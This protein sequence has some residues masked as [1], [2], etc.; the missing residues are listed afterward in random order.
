MEQWETFERG[1]PRAP[2]FALELP[3][4]Y[5]RHGAEQWEEGRMRNI[6]RSGLLF[7]A[8]RAF[9]VNTRIELTFTLPRVI[10][11][12]PPGAVR[13]QSQV[14]RSFPLGAEKGQHA[15]AV[16]IMDYLFTRA[17]AAALTDRA[18]AGKL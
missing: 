3:V 12:E 5:R 11:N 17:S 14:A 10:P 4:L 7:S 1:Q 15:V 6:S 8:E 13:C 16:S 9:S 18:E 2:R